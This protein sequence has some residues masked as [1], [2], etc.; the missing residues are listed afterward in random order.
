MKKSFAP[1]TL[2]LLLILATTL[3]LAQ[4]PDTQPNTDAADLAGSLDDQTED[5]LKRE[6]DIPK[7][8]EIPAKVLF[9]IEDGITWQHLIIVLGVWIGFFIVILNIMDLLPFMNKGFV[10]FAGALVITAITSITGALNII[11]TFFFDVAG[12]FDW[13]GSWGPL[14][15]IIAVL[16]AGIV[17][18]LVQWVTKKIGNRNKI[19]KA[20]L[21]GKKI[22]DTVENSK[23]V[24]K[25]N[26]IRLGE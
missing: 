2:I 4:D 10:K 11:A 21:S 19:E 20:E 26:K 15:I 12:F 9:G 25:L 7:I 16:I 17:I 24:D 5:L 3:V 1:L 18:F 8:L 14:Q 6:V 23:A 22:R 13:V